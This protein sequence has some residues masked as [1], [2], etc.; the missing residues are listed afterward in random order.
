MACPTVSTRKGNTNQNIET[1]TEN[2]LTN[3]II[4]I[5][6]KTRKGIIKVNTGIRTNIDIAPVLLRIRRSMMVAI[7]KTRI[8][9]VRL[10]RTRN[11]RVAVHLTKIRKRTKPGT[12]NIITNPAR[13][14][15]IKTGKIKK[16][17]LK[18]S[19]KILCNNF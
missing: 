14:P 9:R 12:K 19:F 7:V 17:L 8:E 10:V 13:A 15:K 2:D 5:G 4:K 16:C 11:I 3:R 6:A 1:R 18:L